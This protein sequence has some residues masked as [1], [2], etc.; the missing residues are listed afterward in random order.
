MIK[1]RAMAGHDVFLWIYHQSECS[2]C[3]MEPEYC[4]KGDT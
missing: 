2:R 3:G 1:Y 4:E